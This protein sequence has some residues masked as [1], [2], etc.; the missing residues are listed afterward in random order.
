MPPR[1]ASDRTAK[2][3][4]IPSAK[5][6]GRSAKVKQRKTATENTNNQ[7]RPPRD[8]VGSVPAQR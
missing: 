5:R 7:P 2:T 1:G 6:T 3:A 8:D 4:K